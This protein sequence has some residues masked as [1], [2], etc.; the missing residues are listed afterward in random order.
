M[1]VGCMQRG[2]LSNALYLHGEILNH[3]WSAGSA[4][5]VHGQLEG[6]FIFALIWSLGATG[7]TDGRA[8]FDVFFRSLL[9]GGLL[10]KD[11]QELLPKVCTPVSFN[12]AMTPK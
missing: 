10:E 3:P 8:A 11:L 9:G 12:S 5:D 1:P 6:I 2:H 4:A 7:D